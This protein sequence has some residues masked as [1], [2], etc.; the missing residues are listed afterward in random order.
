MPHIFSVCL[1]TSIAELWYGLYTWIKLGFH[2]SVLDNQSFFCNWFIV[3]DNFHICICN[4]SQFTDWS[5]RFI[6][7]IFK[8]RN[9]IGW[10]TGDWSKCCESV[11]I[12]SS[13]PPHPLLLGWNKFLK[14]C[15]PLSRKGRG[16]TFWGKHLPEVRTAILFLWFCGL[17]L[18]GA[19]NHKSSLVSKIQ[20]KIAALNKTFFSR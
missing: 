14:N 11:F 16:A 3:M 18:R 15:Y 7:F 13:P 9:L 10:K 19:P 20:I 17:L 5:K 4:Q 1:K 6:W 12:V 8:L 2:S